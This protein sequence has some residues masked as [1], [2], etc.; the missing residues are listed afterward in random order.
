MMRAVEAKLAA[1]DSD[2]IKAIHARLS[3]AID[4]LTRAGAWVVE[5]VSEGH[6]RAALASAVPFLRLFGVV[7][8]GWQMARAAL[9]AQARLDAGDADPFYQA[10]IRTAHFFG[11]H[12]LTQ[13]EGLAT[14]VAEA[15]RRRWPCPSI[16][17]ERCEAPSGDDRPSLLKRAGMS[18]ECGQVFDC[19]GVQRDSDDSGFG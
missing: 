6:T 17:S 12:L 13:A 14:T 1:S 9:V 2:D 10:K 11:D 5:K 8:A 15:R 3:V 19:E 7:A 4:A 16:S 18:L